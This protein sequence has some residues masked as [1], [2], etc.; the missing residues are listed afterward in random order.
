MLYVLELAN[1]QLEEFRVMDAGLDRYF[2]RVYDDLEGTRWQ[3]AR[4]ASP[5]LRALRRFRLDVA[6]LADE[7]T[8]ITKFFGDWYLARVYLGAR[9]RFHLDHWRSSVEERLAEL[10]QLYRVAQAEQYERR[11]FWLEVIIVVLFV[12]DVV[13]LFVLRK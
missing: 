4:L 10:D 1:L 13:G 5:T 12:I 2:N 7:V 8:H 3:L 11:M 9:E 6:R